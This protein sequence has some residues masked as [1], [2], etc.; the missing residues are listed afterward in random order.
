M[1]SAVRGAAA[2][3]SDVGVMSGNHDIDT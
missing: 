2:T 1:I 3:T